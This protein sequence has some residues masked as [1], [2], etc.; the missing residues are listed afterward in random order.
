MGSIVTRRMMTTA[1]LLVGAIV[2]QWRHASPL[3]ATPD[4]RAPRLLSET[5]LYADAA[6]LT[7]DPRNRPFAPQYPLWTDGAAKRRWVHLPEGTTVDVSRLDRWTFP[8]GTRFWKEFSFGGRKVETRLLWKTR[9][10]HWEFA[11]Y[12]WNDAQTDAVL[13]PEGGMPD[14]AEVAP[15][16]SHSIPGVADCR[17]CHD[18]SRTEIL[19]FSALQLS[20]DRDPLAPHAE[21][22]QPG[23]VTLR[24]LVEEG[25]LAP[26]RTDL[27]ARPPRIA[28]ADPQ[29]RAALG[30]LSA[31]CAHCHNRES[32]IASLGLDLQYRLERGTDTCVPPAVAT[33][34]GKPG[35]WLVPAVPE[36]TSQLVHA[37]RP[38]L[39]A[40]IYRMNSR[41][42]SSQMP[43]IGTVLVDHDAAALM[44]AW[45]AAGAPGGTGCRAFATP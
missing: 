41:R 12:A 9:P 20:N 11:S 16:K 33:T 36:G 42:P 35:H 17:S 13:V 21:P 25:K 27:V 19:G 39:S 2:F 15:G 30:Y 26:A 5:G 28:A 10:D 7:I 32:S 34:V 45:V 6:T 23:M 29:A 14:A 38:D 24:T 3:G 18:S 40:V 44:A 8:V 31:N 43:P 22:L 37:G 1:L 4:A